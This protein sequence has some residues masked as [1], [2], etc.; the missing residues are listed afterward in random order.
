MALPQKLKI[1]SD[2]AARNVTSQ[3]GGCIFFSSSYLFFPDRDLFQ[4]TVRAPGEGRKKDKSTST[5]G[6]GASGSS[7]GQ[8]RRWLGARQKVSKIERRS[9]LASQG[10]NKNN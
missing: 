5:S 7:E 4:S 3:K 8:K 2:F 9:R 6:P 10:L 1:S